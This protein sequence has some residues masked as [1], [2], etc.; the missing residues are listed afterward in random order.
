MASTNE[1]LG[2]HTSFNDL[3]ARKTIE[4]IMSNIQENHSW[5]E[6]I[7]GQIF[8]IIIGGATTNTMIRHVIGQNRLF[9][10]GR[11]EMFALMPKFEYNVNR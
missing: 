9:S 2:Y 5:H 8:Q 11:I 1:I 7:V 4:F 10:N 6:E 3:A